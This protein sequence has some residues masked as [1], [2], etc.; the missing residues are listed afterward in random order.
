MNSYSLWIHMIISYMNSYMYEFIYMDS[1]IWNH[2]NC[3]FMYE[4]TWTM[5]HMNYEFIWFFHIWIHIIHE[6]IYEFGCTKVQMYLNNRAEGTRSSHSQYG[7]AQASVQQA[8]YK[9]PCPSK[10]VLH[11]P[12]APWRGPDAAVNSWNV[13]LL[14][15]FMY[16]WHDWQ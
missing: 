6:F 7:W 10:P 11:L 14:G 4:L 9:A 5:D 1:Y 3:E 16:H 13:S 12:Q 15:C 8:P 2:M